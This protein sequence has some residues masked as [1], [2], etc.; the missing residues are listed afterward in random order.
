MSAKEDANA[1]RRQTVH[2]YMHPVGKGRGSLCTYIYA[3]SAE[4]VNAT[5]YSRDTKI[6]IPTESTQRGHDT[7]F[8]DFN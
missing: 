6:R 2:I 4:R 7:T 8:R 1:Q 3:S 5:N